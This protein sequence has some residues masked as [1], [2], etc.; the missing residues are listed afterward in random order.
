VK[1]APGQARDYSSISP[2][3][4]SL[5]LMKAQTSLP[6][7]REA[8]ALV[9]GHAAPAELAEAMKGGGATRNLKHFQKRYRS[10][11]TLLRESGLPRVLEI[12]AGLSF[13]GL[14]LARTSATHYIDSD[15]P[16]I[17]ELKASLIAKLCPEPLV[18][19]LDVRAL[20]ALDGEAF[21]AT[22][23]RLPNGPIA[24]VNEGLLIYLDELEKERLAR[25][26]RKA[27]LRRGG[28]WLTADVYI[29]N[30]ADYPSVF[31]EPTA[32]AFLD[33]HRVDDNKFSSWAA[34]ERFFEASGFTIQRKLVPEHSRHVRESWALS[35]AP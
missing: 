24:I 27:L 4:L 28:V 31:A 34:A 16:E 32:R 21:D 14:E 13:R 11:D 15:L 17:A 19:T 33:Q 30:P 7:A 3:A 9:Y 25:H 35:A 12:G 29:R 5:L 26:V 2:S 20:D 10:L 8:A 1:E 23:E 18:G 6:F 22:V